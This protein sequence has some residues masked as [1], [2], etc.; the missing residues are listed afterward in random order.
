MKTS[1]IAIA[2]AALGISAGAS[3]AACTPGGFVSYDGTTVVVDT[4][5]CNLVAVDSVTG[6]GTLLSAGRLAVGDGTFTTSIE[7]GMIRSNNG[8]D[9]NTI[10]T[11]DGVAVYDNGSIAVVTS[12]GVGVSNSAGTT[13][14]G[15]GGVI[16][17]DAGGNT[18]VIAPQG[19]ATTGV[20]LA[21]GVAANVV[22]AGVLATQDSAGTV[23]GNVGDTLS[24]HGSQLNALNGR[25]DEAFEGVAMALAMESPQVDPGKRF[26][27]SLNYGNFEGEGAFAAAAKLRFDE[28]FAG[29]A[30][31]GYGQSG[32][33]GFRAGVQ[34][35]W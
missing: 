22:E 11:P 27:I 34:A 8:A 35:Q 21:N 31:V 1:A 10:L 7:P 20:V 32:T 24:Q 23:Y 17:Q 25:V 4:T 30:G 28:N 3:H 16:T 12:S 14:M 2:I 13:S 26:G 33:V 6:Q 15:G 18:T 29:T 9:H 5:G 19:I